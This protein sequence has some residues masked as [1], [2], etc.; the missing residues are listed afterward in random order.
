MRKHDRKPKCDLASDRRTKRVVFARIESEIGKE[1]GPIRR[2][3]ENKVDLDFFNNM[4]MR[5]RTK[6]ISR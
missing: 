6:L 3:S 2:A 1:A 5:F 4:Q